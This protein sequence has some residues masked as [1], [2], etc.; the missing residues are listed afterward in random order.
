MRRNIS[1]TWNWVFFFIGIYVL[2][3]GLIFN[4]NIVDQSD[5]DAAIV[6]LSLSCL[7]FIALACG[8]F[9]NLIAQIKFRFTSKNYRIK[10][11][12]IYY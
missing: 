6:C 2:F 1:N 7:C 5:F 12:D 4:A 3:M 11:E 9:Y 8:L 10:K